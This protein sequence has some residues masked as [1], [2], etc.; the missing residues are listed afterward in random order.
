MRLMAGLVVLAF[1]IASCADDE[2]GGSSAIEADPFRVHAVAE[3]RPEACA[4]GGDEAGGEYA[5]DGGCLVLEAA[6]LGARDV[7]EAREES[8][9]G[10]TVVII[11]LTP[12]GA[13][14]FDALAA[15][16]VG[17]RLAI[18]VG[19]EVVNAPVVQEAQFGGAIQVSGLSE[20]D[21]DSLVNALTS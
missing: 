1:I 3:E 20:A 18:V 13:D 6:A 10:E 17:A 14:R 16:N 11:S 15:E 9:G 7:S 21:A 2:P 5:F 4:T 12:A 19:G 8:V